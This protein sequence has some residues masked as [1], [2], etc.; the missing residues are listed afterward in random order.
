VKLPGEIVGI[1]SGRARLS[2]GRTANNEVQ[3]AWHCG[4]TF[5]CR[6]GRWALRFGIPA[7]GLLH[8]AFGA[9]PTD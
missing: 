6:H 7:S 4:P 1:D 3:V 9:R 8:Y 5:R 2:E